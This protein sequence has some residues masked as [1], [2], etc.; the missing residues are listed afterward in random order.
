[1]LVKNI[2]SLKTIAEVE[3]YR[4]KINE[5][6]DK[7]SNL[8]SIYTK[9]NELSQKDF[10]VIKESFEAMSPE[11]FKT[12]EGKAVMN[13][14]TKVIKESKNLSALH[15]IYEN[16]RKA[17]T[18]SD[19]DFFINKLASEKWNVDKKTVSEDCKK[20]GRILAEG[21]ILIEG[22]V[23]LPAAN[24]ELDKAV[25]FVS[26][27]EM[28]GKNIAEYS[29][30]VKII[31][32][33]VEKNEIVENTFK[34]KN[35]EKLAEEMVEEFNKKYSST[36]NEGEVDALK[37]ISNSENREETF[38]KYKKA[39]MDKLSEAK[40]NFEKE[41]N[42]AATEKINSIMEQV[43]EKKFSV[44]TVGNDVCG[45]IKLSDIF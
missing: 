12:K 39:C 20:L 45:M 6:C 11:L 13:K 15:S 7:R 32:E 10:G 40:Q 19:I 37:E 38:E 28:N 41:N 24:T 16:I 35:I 14:Y 26:E 22:N 9:A 25:N 2:N 34:A 33:N 8:I 3:E 5:A 1:M 31:R 42:T 23:V 17:N 4:K 30:A 29:K 18:E 36:L 44:D 21:Y 43:S 27:N